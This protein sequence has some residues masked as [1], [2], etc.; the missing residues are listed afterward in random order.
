MNKAGKNRN[1]LLAT[2]LLLG[3]IGMPS[4][5]LGESEIDALRK[6]AEEATRKG[7]PDLAIEATKKI[8]AIR[9]ST[10]GP[11][12]PQV[13]NTLLSLAYN[14]EKQKQYA[15]AEALYQRILAINE[16]A[17]GPEHPDTVKALSDLSYIYSLQKK[18]AEDLPLS[19]RLL[20]YNEKTFGPDHGTTAI[21]LDNLAA[22]YE[23]LGQQEKAQPLRKRALAIMGIGQGTEQQNQAEALKGLADREVNQGRYAQAEPLYKRA[24]A[25]YEEA[26]GPEHPDTAATLNNLAGLYTTQARYAQAEPLFKRTLAIYEKIRGPAHPETATALNNLAGLYAAQGQLAQAEPLYRRALAIREKALGPDHPDVV[27]SLRSLAG[28]YGAQGQHAQAESLYKRAIDS[29]GPNYW[30]DPK[31]FALTLSSLASLYRGQGRYAEAEPLYQRALSITEKAAGLGPE[32]PGTA[33]VLEALAFLY[34]SQGKQAQAEPLY[35]RALAIHEKTLEPNHPDLADAMNGLALLYYGQNRPAQALPLTRKASAIYRERIVAGGA[36][37]AS[38]REAARYR[39][40]LLLHIYILD[41][42]SNKNPSAAI[43]NES[44]E[45]VQLAQASGTAGA[46]A[47][48]A[49]R[50][51]KGDDA[52]ATLAKRKQDA[53]ER[54]EILESTLLKTFSEAADKRDAGREQKLRDDIA[55]LRREVAAV[56][57]ELNRRFPEYQEL[58]RPEPLQI[59]QVRKLLKPGEAM[60]VYAFDATTGSHAWVVSP[61]KAAFLRLDARLPELEKDVALVRSQMEIDGRG[62]APAVS[63]DVLHRLYRQLFTPALPYLANVKHL[64]VVPSGPLVSLPFG[65]LV[66]SAP[67][68]GK[69]QDYA[70]IDWLVKR[71]ATSVLPSVSSIR[72]FRQ[73][74]RSGIAQEPFAGYGDPVIGEEEGGTR[75]MRGERRSVNAA[76]LFRATATSASRQAGSEVADVEVIRKQP[77]LADTADELLFVAKALKARPEQALWLQSRATETNLKQ[78]DLS[79]YR[80]LAFATHGVMAGQIDGV[81]EPGL[82]LT[83]PA[84]G[85]VEDDGY[86]AASEIARLKLNADWVIL[87]AC[88]TAAGDGTPGAEGFSGL[89]KAFFH[90]GSRSLLVSHWPV[91]SQATVQLVG[92]M[93]KDYEA[94]P[95]LTKTEAQRRSMLALM[96]N[97]EFAHPAFWAPFVVVGEGGR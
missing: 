76:A 6:Q 91:A 3:A 22:L 88:N 23:L 24:L 53:Q 68:A 37:S 74:A 44:F 49:A 92:A 79:K 47:K 32:H 25:I 26:S 33:T 81:G 34:V 59:A 95:A 78:A 55:A 60:L 89:T 39:R 54:L 28:F 29:M 94:N 31:G 51:A 15:Q 5:A 16:K 83:P 84:V 97:P 70:N 85:T 80:V 71:Y 87:S 11:D 4:Y 56:D 27:A 57:A 38:A 12:H 90:A 36:D 13:V 17:L 21:S 67:A 77:R 66:A 9:E 63:T 69:G 58:V 73:F 35:Q 50:F 42:I 20:A 75:A 82:I 45:I 18:Y 40:L 48:M 61:D 96:A 10:L 7:Q 86:L 46:V 65:M 72:A 43:A 30:Q 93:L 52:L 8:L 14:Y 62:V 1:L 64:M 19:K 41:R 2:C